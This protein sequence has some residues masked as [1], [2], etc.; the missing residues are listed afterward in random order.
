MCDLEETI[1]LMRSERC[2][3]T[4]WVINNTE[5]KSITF[6][7]VPESAGSGRNK[8]FSFEYKYLACKKGISDFL[9]AE[10]VKISGLFAFTISHLSSERYVKTFKFH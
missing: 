10:V 6:S 2:G 4:A 9:V 7:P 8:S 3:E 5:N 1:N